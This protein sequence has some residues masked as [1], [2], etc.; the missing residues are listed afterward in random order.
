M[1]ATITIQTYN[2]AATTHVAFK[3][4]SARFDSLVRIAYTAG[5]VFAGAR[6]LARDTEEEGHD[7]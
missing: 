3:G 6:A 1:F 5:T 2:H 7:R 4:S